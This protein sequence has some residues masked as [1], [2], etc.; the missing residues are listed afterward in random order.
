MF[1]S[2]SIDYNRPLEQNMPILSNTIKVLAHHTILPLKHFLLWG[3][4]SP[5]YAL[6]DNY[7]VRFFDYLRF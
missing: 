1:Y 6:F 2:S 5:R 4:G 7:P 3:S